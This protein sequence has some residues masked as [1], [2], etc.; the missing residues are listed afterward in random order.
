VFVADLGASAEFYERLLGRPADLIP[1]DWEAAWRLHEGAWIVLI[2]ADAEPALA[3]GAQHTLIVEDLDGFLGAARERGIE[4]GPV[5]P[6]G[7]GMRQSVVLDP[8]G[9][10]L[11]V[12]APASEA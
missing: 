6:V 11:K 1:N 10:R 3:G 2:A 9:N 5:E 8:D 4:P 7:E 12:A